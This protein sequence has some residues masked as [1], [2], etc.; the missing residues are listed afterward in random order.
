MLNTHACFKCMKRMFQE[1]VGVEDHRKVPHK[2]G[3]ARAEEFRAHH[4]NGN[5][6]FGKTYWDLLSKMWLNSGK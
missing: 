3:K 1:E 2:E 6:I 4:C 5:R